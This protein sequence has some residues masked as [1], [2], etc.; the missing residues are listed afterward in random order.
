MDTLFGTL[1]Y[2]PLQFAL[3]TDVRILKLARGKGGFTDEMIGNEK[4]PPV[5]RL[6]GRFLRALRLVEM[7]KGRGVWSG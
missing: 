3:Q 5:G 2:L 4:S 7:T 1:S 6:E